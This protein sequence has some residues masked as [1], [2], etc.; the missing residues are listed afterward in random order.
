MSQPKPELHYE[1]PELNPAKRLR[2]LIL[3]IADRAGTD[4][5]FGKVKLAK[6]LYFADFE[7]YRLYGKAITG[8]KY[9]K[10]QNGPVPEDFFIALDEMESSGDLLLKRE[11]YFAYD[12]HRV[13]ACREPQLEIFNGR[14]IA[15]IDR[16][17]DNF[18]NKTATEIS[19]LS[20]GVAWQ[21]AELKAAIPYEAAILSDEGVTDE[22]IAVAEELIE[23]FGWDE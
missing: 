18:R 9:V 11:K 23:E 17:I 4:D 6:I 19:N 22:D 5:T 8:T 1:F 12:K 3:H 21:S 13:I 7:S 20:H 15:L 16:L 2:E 10:L 14:D